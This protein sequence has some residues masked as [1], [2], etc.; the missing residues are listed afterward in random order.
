MKALNSLKNRYYYTKE[1]KETLKKY[2]PK[3]WEFKVVFESGR[4][5]VVYV[6]IDFGKNWMWYGILENVLPQIEKTGSWELSI[7]KVYGP[8][9]H[10][11]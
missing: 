11:V 7:D 3:G 6:R 8:W 2:L 1:H 9:G 5:E 4:V 10:V